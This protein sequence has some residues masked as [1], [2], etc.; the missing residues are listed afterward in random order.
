MREKYQIQNKYKVQV[1]R[2]A[3]DN[4]GMLKESTIQENESFLGSWRR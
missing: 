4:L 3:Y 2:I 1:Q